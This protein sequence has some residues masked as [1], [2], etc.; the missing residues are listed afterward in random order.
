MSSAFASPRMY[1]DDMRAGVSNELAVSS[2]HDRQ[3][4][5]NA[6]FSSTVLGWVRRPSYG[7]L[8]RTREALTSQLRSPRTMPR[9]WV[10]S[11]RKRG[12]SRA[13]S[14]AGGPG[15]SMPV[16]D[17][18]HEWV[19]GVRVVPTTDRV[20][21]ERVAAVL[22]HA[23]A[24]SLEE[25]HEAGVRHGDVKPAN[26]LWTGMILALTRRPVVWRR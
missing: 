1:H 8:A 23:V 24:R 19:D 2:G 9:P 13:A 22:A 25:L 20:A 7:V 11:P 4:S 26:V 12:S 15:C 14:A 3:S 5:K 21:R 6:G 17:I 10:P 16:P 18:C